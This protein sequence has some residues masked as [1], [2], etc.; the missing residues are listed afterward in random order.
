[1]PR[2]SRTASNGKA[3]GTERKYSTVCDMQKQPE[4]A[5]ALGA[6]AAAREVERRLPGVSCEAAFDGR[7]YIVTIAPLASGRAVEVAE[8][9]IARSLRGF[10]DAVDALLRN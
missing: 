6:E 7:Y 8:A 4:H 1:M 10:R 5:A 3:C 2:R 9:G